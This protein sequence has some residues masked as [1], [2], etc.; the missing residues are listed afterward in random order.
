[1]PP[2][3]SVDGYV[4]RV[5]RS[6]HGQDERI[7][8]MVRG[9]RG[10]KE[11]GNCA[12]ILGNGGS[13][14][15]AQHFAQDLLKLVG[16]RAQAVTCPSLITA[17]SNDASFQR[18]FLDPIKV[19]RRSGDPVIIFSCSGKSRNYSGFKRRIDGLLMAVVGTDGGFLAARADVCVKVKSMDY[20]VCETAFCVVADLILKELMNA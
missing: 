10:A 14:A 20:Q 1:M 6:L 15:I 13:L 11:R 3:L 7:R 18:V 2:T 8:A 9:L 4:A 5:G 17:Y 12:W 16:I 19:L